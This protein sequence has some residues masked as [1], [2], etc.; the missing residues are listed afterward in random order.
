M[1]VFCKSLSN[2]SD[3][4]RFTLDQSHYFP[5]IFNPD[6]FIRSPFLFR[7]TD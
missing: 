3:N 5:A 2:I 1:K 7:G 6:I 4:V